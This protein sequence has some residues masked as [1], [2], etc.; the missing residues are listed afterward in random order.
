MAI[1]RDVTLTLD[2]ASYEELAPGLSSPLRAALDAA[3]EGKDLDAEQAVAVAEAR[4]PD[5]IAVAA[6][7]DRLAAQAVRYGHDCRQVRAPSLGHRHGL[8]RV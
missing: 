3:L 7:A 5:L 1:K 6:V 8:L 4:G 2:G